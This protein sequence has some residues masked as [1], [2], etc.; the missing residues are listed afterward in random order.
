MKRK[1]LFAILFCPALCLMAQIPYWTIHPNYTSI[2]ILGNGLYV[3]SQ[4]DKYGMLNSDEEVIV[5]LKYDSISSFKSHTA[6]L[7]QGG[8]FVAIV[9]DKGKVTDVASKSYS[10]LEGCLFSDGYLPV[11][12][13]SGCF[14]IKAETGES[15][16]P[17]SDER[18]FYEG[19]AVVKEPKSL[20][21]IFDGSSVLKCLSAETGMPIT[22]SYD[23]SD[24]EDLDFIS[25]VSN[26]KSIVVIKKRVFEYDYRNGLITPLSSDGTDNKKSRV[27]VS[28]RPVVLT[29]TEKGF[30]I[31][32]KQGLMTFDSQLR[33]TGI[34]YNGQELKTYEPPKEKNPEFKSPFGYLSYNDTKL[35]GLSYNE[36]EFLPAQ[37]EEIGLL[38]GNDALVK[39]DGKYGVISV[40]TKN[41]CKY[42]LNDNFDI[43]F[44]HKALKTNVKVVC[45]PYMKLPLMSLT[46]FDENCIINTDTRKESSNVESVV[47][48]YDCTLSIPEKIGLER[49]PCYATLGLKYDGLKYVPQE[50]SFNTWYINNYTVELP[51]H[52]VTDE[53]LDVD[54]LV[55]NN[56]SGV[57]AFFKDVAIEAEDSVSCTITKITEELYNARLY[58]WKSEKVNFNIDVTEDACPTITYGFS[59]DVKPYKDNKKQPEAV[60]VEKP[61]AQAKVKRAPKKNHATPKKEERKKFVL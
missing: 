15:I 14:Y 55:K 39:S 22:I 16:G 32:L 41:S 4:N 7:Y 26:G 38:W 6:L 1:I 9:N 19:Y 5:P 44:E 36:K 11:I 50:I 24:D 29:K 61:V 33:L 52:R 31:Q 18:P 56:T 25:S 45:P 59:L 12:N 60:V 27:Y 51:K 43:G 21:H 35:F 53:V 46:S 8:K 48:S 49:T 30:S 40:D 13:N 28:E 42:M 3:V 54:I 47:L 58:G 17:Y 37:F 34:Q 10:P 20:K 2:C 23:K 57:Q